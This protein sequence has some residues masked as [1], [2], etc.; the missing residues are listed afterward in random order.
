MKRLLTIYRGAKATTICFAVAAMLPAAA[1]PVVKTAAKS[2]PLEPAPRSVFEMPA[3]PG[4]GRDP[5]FPS[6][7]RPYASSA[8]AAP[9]PR[10]DAS[11]L[12]VKGI[13]YSRNKFYAIIN[14]HTFAAGD[15]WEVT[16]SQGHTHVRCLEI[17]GNSVLVEVDGKRYELHYKE[18][19]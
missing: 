8:P 19:L 15:E 12:V 3:N 1:A 11:A 18:N 6:S 16:T 7:L 9:V 4:E 10:E 2:A 13:S 14:D 5:F 17:N